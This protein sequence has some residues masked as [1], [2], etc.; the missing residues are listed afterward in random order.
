MGEEKPQPESLPDFGML[1]WEDLYPR[2]LLRAVRKIRRMAWR[3]ELREQIPGGRTAHDAVQTAVEKLLAG[4]RQ[5]N[6]RKSAY[7]NL[8]GAVSS[9]ISNWGTSAENRMTSRISDDEKIVRLPTQQPGPEDH[10]KW[11]LL[12][13]RFLKYLRAEDREVA[14]M[15]ELMLDKDLSGSSELAE[16]MGL[17]PKEIDAIKKRLKRLAKAHLGD[18]DEADLENPG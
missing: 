9:E 16:A 6:W 11:R 2:L 13:D 12:C 4:E 17:M 7:D 5:W 15:A 1:P 8:W 14:R 18:A 10:T 3:G